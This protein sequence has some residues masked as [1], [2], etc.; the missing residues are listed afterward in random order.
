MQPLPESTDV[1]SVLTE[2]LEIPKDEA[3]V[4]DADAS[5]EDFDAINEVST[6]KEVQHQ[7]DTKDTLSV[8]TVTETVES[9][10]D[11]FVVGE[12]SE[13]SESVERDSTMLLVTNKTEK[14]SIFDVYEADYNRESSTS[15]SITTE[16]EVQVPQTNQSMN[17]LLTNDSFPLEL[18][19][20][21]KFAVFGVKA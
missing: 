20:T 3:A 16:A 18:T 21:A 17:S 6:K 7:V 19:Q 15:P 11:E 9:P 10:K 13:A 14:F 1:P 5:S 12:S 8:L 2:A 4:K